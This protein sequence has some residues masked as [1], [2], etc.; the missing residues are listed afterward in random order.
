MNSFIEQLIFI[1]TVGGIVQGFYLVLLLNNRRIRKTSANFCLSI[2]LIALSFSI[3]HILYGE[4]IFNHLL[5]NVYSIGDPTFLLIA[6][7]LWLYVTELTGRRVRLTVRLVPHFIPFALI[8]LFSLTFRIIP[9]QTFT[10]FIDQQYR[11][12]GIFFWVLVVVQFSLYLIFLHRQLRRHHKLIQ[13]EVSNTE[14]Y[15]LEWIQFFMSVFTIINLYFLFSLFVVIHLDH[16]NWLAKTT[17]LIFSLSVFALG[18]K[19]LLQ[20][21]IFLSAEESQERGFNNNPTNTSFVCD[22]K[23]ITRLKA[24]MEE[25]KPYLDP[26]LT[27]TS[28]AKDLCITRS[29]LSQ[30][31]NSGIG[32]NFYD[33]INKYRV[34]EVKRL[35]TDPQKNHFS[36]LGV[37]LEAG[38][39]SKSTFNL[40]F[41]R[42]TG[43]TPS[44]YRKNISD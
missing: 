44:E 7:L 11:V 10:Q 9:S 38:F 6:P 37:A 19:G 4:K 26:E 17:A 43:I 18:Y 14:D 32:N 39:K 40:I 2:L 21:E 5:T 8:I 16:Q 24:H 3:A 33:F 23:L 36:L 20:R 29:Q 41:K 42:F 31:I 34:E 28:L 35:M 27:L 30:V 22:Q 1:L 13:Q 12:I 25:K 15:N